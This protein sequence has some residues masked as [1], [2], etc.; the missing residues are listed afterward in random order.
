M[1]AASLLRIRGASFDF[2]SG[3]LSMILLM[4]REDWQNDLQQNDYGEGS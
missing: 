1:I 4:R 3:L 2:V